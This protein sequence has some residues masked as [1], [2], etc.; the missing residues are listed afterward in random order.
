MK[1]TLNNL[2]LGTA[3]LESTAAWHYGHE[4]KDRLNRPPSESLRAWEKAGWLESR[5]EDGTPESLKRALRI[6]Y[7]LTPKGWDGYHEMLHYPGFDV[8]GRLITAG[9]A[10]RP[11]QAD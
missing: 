2:R 7:R 6:Q 10:K 9:T 4:L 5:R 11:P 3:F 8:S 1:T